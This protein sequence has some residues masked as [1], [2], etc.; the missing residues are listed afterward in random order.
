MN[1][2]SRIW[3]GY[4]ALRELGLA[5]VGLNALYRI[6]L[7]TGH[8][9]RQLDATLH[10]L[11]DINQGTQLTLHPCLPDLP[12]GD[13][14]HNL[15]RDQINQ[16]YADAD[17]IVN[18]KVRLFGGGPVP[19]SLNSPEPM[20]YW[21]Q[22]ERGINRI[23]ELD[24]KFIWEPARF[25]WACTL[26]RAYHLSGDERYADAFWQY[27]EQF[28]SSNPPY[29]GPHWSSAQEVAIR[30]IALS[31]AI[32]VF[33][34]SDRSTPDRLE[35]LARAI[36]FMAGR[37]PPTLVY[38]RSQNNNHLITEA[39]GLY[40]A[41][42]LLRDHPLAKDWHALGWHWLMVALGNQIE[43]DG[44]YVQFSTNYHRLMLQAALWAS[45]VDHLSFKKSSFPSEVL[46]NLEYSTRWLANILDPLTG[47][48]PNSGHNDGADILPLT[49]C[50]F[51]D[52]KPVVYASMQAFL[53][54]KMQ[55]KGPWNELSHWLG[56]SHWPIKSQ[57]NILT[58]HE[59]IISN[60]IPIRQ[61]YV[62]VN[63]VANSW[64]VIHAC[65]YRT[66]PAHADQLHTDI[67]WRGLNL[68]LDP[69]T[70]LYN[71]VPPWDNSLTSSFV[72]NTVTVDGKEF[73]Q[74][75]GRFLFLN[76][77][78]AHVLDYHYDPENRSH[79]L[80]ASHN[81]YRNLGITHSRTIT[82]FQDGHWEVDDHLDGPPGQ[83]HTIRLHWLLPDWEYEVLEAQDE[84]HIPNYE[85]RIR[86]PYGWVSL[87]IG[88]APS[89]TKIK[90]L[91]GINFSLVRAGTIVFGLGAASPIAG[92]A[93]PTYGEKIPA[94]ACI[95]EVCQFLPL[96]LK[97]EW[98]LPGES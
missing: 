20:Q 73:M 35:N 9:Q 48:T 22:Y 92:W 8:Y 78:Q 44:T 15:L 59:Q 2:T 81:G 84:N 74:R 68:A 31:F 45:A 66:R 5:Q 55:D 7:Q 14:L 89:S 83:S 80:T 13:E 19:L 86:S 1:N 75:V 62:L 18:G 50:S 42:T 58:Y 4:K 37:I 29:M 43:T 30:I 77:A 3:V 11:K 51:N 56:I 27:T 10:R 72:H 53:G 25:G 41:S 87:K 90:S 67:W 12:D 47:C 38:A 60:E 34:Q 24:I 40:T 98:I 63:Q 54:I 17:E 97:S 39:L 26:A 23:S 21:T 79:T 49:V 61:P 65:H 96:V 6:G 46:L 52:Y 28:I 95:F 94:L 69:G 64:A 91:P 70:Y 93:S 82:T 32:Q 85:I 76:W 36:T 33:K 88:I 71:D 57:E 16:L